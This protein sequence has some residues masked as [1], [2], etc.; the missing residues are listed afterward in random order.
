MQLY[1]D[2]IA[3][4]EAARLAANTSNLYGGSSSGM[5]GVASGGSPLSLTG[6]SASPIGSGPVVNDETSFFSLDFLLDSIPKG[7]SPDP[8]PPSPFHRPYWLMRVLLRTMTT[9]GYLTPKL[10]VPR[11][12]WFQTGLKLTSVSSKFMSCD[13]ALIYLL[14][15]DKENVKDRGSWN[16]LDKDL[17]E[18]CT[19]LAKVQNNLSRKLPFIPESDL[20]IEG[21][22]QQG[23][24][25]KGLGSMMDGVVKSVSRAKHNILKEKIADD[26]KYI[27]TVIRLFEKASFL[28]DWLTFFEGQ[29]NEPT[30]ESILNKLKRLG[31]FLYFVVCAFVIR[32]F[33]ILLQRYMKKLRTSF[34]EFE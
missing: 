10:Y 3:Q 1:Q 19:I 5:S 22:K 33:D 12:V 32:D 17:D 4:I 14:K 8:P 18:L 24:V 25:A 31:D 15:M 21:S 23:V 28:E 6:F 2:R 26:T 34:L 20:S 30:A 13:T 7:S 16:K 27:D 29:E 9:G 11:Q